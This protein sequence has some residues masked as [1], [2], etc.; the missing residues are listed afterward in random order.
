MFL[1]EKI[2]AAIPQGANA[3]WNVIR[4]EIDE[5]KN[6]PTTLKRIAN[7]WKL[8]IKKHKDIDPNW[9]YNICIKI[10]RNDAEKKYIKD[11]L[12]IQ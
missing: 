9:L 7:T 11:I 10:A 6:E 3:T 4:Q 5:H 8:V 12:Y 1:D 2:E